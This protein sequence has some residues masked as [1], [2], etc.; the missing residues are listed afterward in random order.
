[1]A[2]AIFENHNNICVF[3]S[4]SIIAKGVWPQCVRFNHYNK[5]LDKTAFV[6][7]YSITPM[8]EQINGIYTLEEKMLLHTH[9]APL[10]A[11]TAKLEAS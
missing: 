9:P 11:S 3:G 2:V 7:D 5:L 8:H 4:G 1:M 6:A 10:L